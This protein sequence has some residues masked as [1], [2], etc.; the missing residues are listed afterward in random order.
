MIGISRLFS[1]CFVLF[2]FSAKMRNQVVKTRSQV[3][4]KCVVLMTHLLEPLGYHDI[5]EAKCRGSRGLMKSQSEE[6]DANCSTIEKQLVHRE[7]CTLGG[8]KL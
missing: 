8:K 6:G 2:C 1:F 3:D 5:S 7:K 4:L